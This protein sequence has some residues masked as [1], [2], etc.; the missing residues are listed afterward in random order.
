MLF[1]SGIVEDVDEE[2][3]LV[4]SKFDNMDEQMTSTQP[5]QNYTRSRKNMR[6]YIGWPP[7]NSVKWSLNEK[8]SPRSLMK[9][10]KPLEHLDLRIISWLRRPRSL[11]QNCFKSEL[12]WRGL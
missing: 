2:K 11:R 3:D 1:R 4:E 12:S 8:K 6:S 7:R 10:I 9:P 5:M